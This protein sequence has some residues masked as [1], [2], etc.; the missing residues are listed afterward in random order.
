MQII[1]FEP[2]EQIYYRALTTY[3]TR[4]SQFGDAR[5]ALEQSAIDLF[6]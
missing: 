5:N 2:T 1:G 3:L 4:N 6:G